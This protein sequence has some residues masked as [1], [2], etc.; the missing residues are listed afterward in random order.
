MVFSAD[1]FSVVDRQ[2]EDMMFKYAAYNKEGLTTGESE[3]YQVLTDTTAMVGVVKQEKSNGELQQIDTIQ[4]GKGQLSLP[5]PE[6]PEEEIMYDMSTPASM[7]MA[8][9]SNPSPPMPM[10][11]MEMAEESEDW[12][13]AEED[14]GGAQ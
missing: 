6:Y 8:R 1:E 9:G 14:Q 11:I 3:K 5:E 12:D 4:F 13:E 7:P 10:P 2:S